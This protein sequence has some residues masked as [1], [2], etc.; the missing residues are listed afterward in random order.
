MS[1]SCCV[2]G[3]AHGASV[4]V[5]MLGPGVPCSMVENA[6]ASTPPAN[7]PQKRWRRIAVRTL[8]AFAGIL[9]ALAIAEYAFYK[10]DN[11]AFPHVNLYV[12]DAELGVRLA[13]HATQRLQFRG[14]PVTD[15][16]V[17]ALGY[18]GTDWAN[19]SGN[20]ILV[21]GD[22]QVFG[23]GVEEDET[24][25]AGLAK[26]TGRIV[27]NGGIPTYGPLE[28]TA[29]VKEVMETRKPTTVVYVVNFVNDLFENERPN[30]DRHAVWDGWAVRKETA[31]KS[32]TSF[33]GRTWLYSKSHLFYAWRRWRYSKGPQIDDRGFESEG[34]WS[35]LA[36]IGETTGEAHEAKKKASESNNA[37]KTER[38]AEVREEIAKTEAEVEGILMEHLEDRGQAYGD[39]YL[40]LRSARGKPGDIVRE[41]NVEEGREIALTARTIRRGVLYRNKLA[42]QLQEKNSS[43]SEILTS[44][45]ALISERGK[46]H[47]RAIEGT[48]VPSVLEARLREVKALCDANGAELVVVA[49]PIDVQVSNAEWAKY[50]VTDPP[51][52]LPTRILL[53]DLITSAES[54]GARAIDV[55]EPLS[56]VSGAAFLDHDIHMTPAGHLAVAT[57]LAAKLKE[58]APLPRPAAGLPIGRTRI[59]DPATWRTTPEAN[60]HGST[61]AKCE[62]TY[63]DEWFRATCLKAHR[64][65]P[66]DIVVTDGGH[67]EASIIHTKSSVT[68]VT[69]LF[70]GEKF[71]ATFHWT[72]HS[73]E[74]VANWPAERDRPLLWFEDEVAS[75]SELVISE[76]ETRLCECHLEVEK[77]AECKVEQ[78]W[79]TGE[80]KATCVNLYGHASPD[81][82]EQYAG[83]CEKLLRCTR[84]E[85]TALPVCK[86]GYANAGATGQC[87]ALCS[88]TRPCESG[89]C[90]PWHGSSLCF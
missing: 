6:H 16:R 26:A 89:T 69:P 40:S 50:G 79:P 83:D 13:P 84:G 62:T 54:M 7:T 68:L 41:Q 86:P 31:P 85:A 15:I 75:T 11:G 27:L 42:A 80:C 67:G 73:Q 82:M 52:M 3:A 77:E 4:L 53:G 1:H 49:L 19:D 48:V 61:K 59:P 8:Q 44:R 9:V 20:E 12:A 55:V 66:T 28:Y 43:L 72:D 57:A 17:N 10:R 51:D 87:L 60:V 25:S 37:T 14:N 38:L 33:P 64:H 29:V 90:T 63:I 56:K 32:T 35:D 74:F 46:L 71:T 24:F 76:A 45:E 81:C 23:L 36:S 58:S 88:P 30:S 18:R 34:T 47:A 78:G 39:N 21:V 65:I 5:W 2:G 70:K 22:S